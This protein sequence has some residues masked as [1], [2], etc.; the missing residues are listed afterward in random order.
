MLIVSLSQ[1][2]SG[3]TVKNSEFRRWL[4][5]QGAEIKSGSKHDKI[6]YKD[7]RSHIGKH[8]SKE[9]GEGLR[10]EILKQLGL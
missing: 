8:L 10:K 3:G 5:E 2:Y 7:K 9:V 1:G 4:I 6:Y